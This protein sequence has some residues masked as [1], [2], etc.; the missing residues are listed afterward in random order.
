MFFKIGA[1]KNSAIFKGKHLCWSLF[2]SLMT[3]SETGRKSPAADDNKLIINNNLR[4][5]QQQRKAF[6]CLYKRIRQKKLKQ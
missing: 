4:Y 2:S 1:I 3:V 6:S 5:E